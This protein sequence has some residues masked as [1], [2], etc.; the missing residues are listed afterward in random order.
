MHHMRR[1]FKAAETGL[2]MDGFGAVKG[3]YFW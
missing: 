3:T 2:S 1:C